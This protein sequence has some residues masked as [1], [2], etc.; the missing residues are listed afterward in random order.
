MNF[1]ESI[2]LLKSLESCFFRIFGILEEK[3]QVIE[4]KIFEVRKAKVNVMVSD[5]ALP[6]LTGTHQLDVEF[7]MPF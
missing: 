7:L 5:T 2:E 1:Q 4:F 6:L 3:L